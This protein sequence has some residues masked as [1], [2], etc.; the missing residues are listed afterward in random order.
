M[1]WDDTNPVTLR[2]SPS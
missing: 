1:K 2:K